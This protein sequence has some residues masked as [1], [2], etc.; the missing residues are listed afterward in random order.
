M[1][2]ILEENSS[3][4]SLRS[5]EGDNEEVAP[6]FRKAD[7]CT[8]ANVALWIEYQPGNQGVLGLIPQLGHMGCRPG[9]H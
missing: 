5:L 1:F 6:L 2:V 4:S 3:Y 9:P 8:L 7:G